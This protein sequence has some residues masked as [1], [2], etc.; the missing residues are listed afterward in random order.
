MDPL[1]LS[2]PK[3]IWRSIVALLAVLILFYGMAGYLFSASYIGENPRWRGINRGPRDFGLQGDTVSFRSEDDIALKAWWIPAEAEARGSIIV[4]HGVDHT[5][6]VMLP[7]ARFLVRGGYNVLAVDLRGHGES[8]AQYASPG[9]LEAR[10]ILGAIRYIRSR[11]ENTPIGV[12]GVSYGAV[13][14]LL[15]ASQSGHIVAVVADGLI[16]PAKTCLRTSTAISCIATGPHLGCE[17]CSRLPAF[18]ACPAQSRW[19]IMHEP[20]SGSGR[21]LGQRLPLLQKSLFLCCL[22]PANRTGLC[23]RNKRAGSCQLC[24]LTKNR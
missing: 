14:A 9:Y 6:K 2:Q 7:R 1:R 18:R 23:Q 17:D 11:K 10:D 20:E 16:R 5:R 4:A 12:L 3:V 19:F 24:G 15:A 8:A 13:A 22:F 21:N